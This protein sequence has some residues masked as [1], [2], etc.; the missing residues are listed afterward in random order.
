MI[1]E[2]KIDYYY[3]QIDYIDEG[4]Y[5]NYIDTFEQNELEKAK[6]HLKILNNANRCLNEYTYFTLNKYAVLKH[7]DADGELIEENITKEMSIK[8][9]T[10]KALKEYHND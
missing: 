9:Y 8:D 4:E 5:A 1:D 2:N 6:N 3:Y 10:L 7:T